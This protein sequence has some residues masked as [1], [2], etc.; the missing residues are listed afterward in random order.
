MPQGNMSAVIL[1]FININRC[2][3][4]VDCSIVDCS[5][6]MSSDKA[7]QLAALEYL[8]RRFRLLM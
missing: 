1:T 8:C 4:I 6:I 3:C 7:E 2:V 5:M